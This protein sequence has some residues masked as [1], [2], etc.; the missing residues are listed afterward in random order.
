MTRQNFAL[1]VRFELTAGSAQGFDALVTET[2]SAIGTAE[3]GTLAYLVHHAEASPLV[4]VF[5]EVYRDREAFEEH[6]R[7]PHVK[8]FLAERGQYLAGDPVVW[9]LE[10][11][12][13][14]IRPELGRLGGE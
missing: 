5:Y 4:R 11:S 2:V 1:A 14:V 8:R 7:Q 6:E 9:R 3:P 13:G 12:A 10:P